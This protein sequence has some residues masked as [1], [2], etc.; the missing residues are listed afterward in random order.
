M[1]VDMDVG[2]LSK[3][4][5]RLELYVCALGCLLLVPQED[6]RRTQLQALLEGN[7]R[8]ELVNQLNLWFEAGWTIPLFKQVRVI[9][10]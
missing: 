1:L 10:F 4:F 9:L 5:S 8:T 3:Q 6:Q 7:K 2:S